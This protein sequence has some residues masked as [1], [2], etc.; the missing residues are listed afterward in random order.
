[1]S[2]DATDTARPPVK[3]PRGRPKT[4]SDERRRSQIIDVARKTFVE[5]SF[6]GTTTDIVAMR[7]KISKQTLYRLF[8]SKSDLF[9][10]VVAAHREMML[11]LPRPDAEDDDPASVLQTIF[12][13]DI[14]EEQDAERQAF[15]HIVMRE[16]GQFPEIAEM[17]R[18]EGIDRSRQMLADWLKEQ[19]TRG[20]LVIDNPLSHARILMDMMF[21][22]MG[23]PKHEFP[24]HAE[25]RRHLER[26]ITVYLNGTK[27]T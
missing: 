25:R 9:L 14:T 8:P 10:A 13:I 26:C 7:C 2:T 6:S 1:M 11:A 24:D 3:R 4:V 22:A 21:G 18:R 19:D 12:M 20:R 5:L 16:G 23:R 15:V 27:A 17:L